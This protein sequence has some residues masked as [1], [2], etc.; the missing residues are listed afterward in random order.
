M[1]IKLPG[2]QFDGGVHTKQCAPLAP[3]PEDPPEDFGNEDFADSTR[4]PPPD[5]KQSQLCQFCGWLRRFDAGTPPLRF[6]H[7]RRSVKVQKTRKHEAELGS[8][9]KPLHTST[10]PPFTAL[11]YNNIYRHIGMGPQPAQWH[12]RAY[13]VLQ[14]LHS[15]IL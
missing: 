9:H 14:L 2:Q 7:R 5:M 10:L 3:H 13:S 4:T 8:G 15:F 12:S 6:G 1:I 11:T